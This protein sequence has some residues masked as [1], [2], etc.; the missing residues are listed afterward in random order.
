MDTQNM[1][2]NQESLYIDGHNFEMTTN[3]NIDISNTNA[4]RLVQLMRVGFGRSV[5]VT[6]V[7]DDT[8]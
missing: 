8:I 7:Q 4:D 5:S 1:D 6:F 2:L 3:G